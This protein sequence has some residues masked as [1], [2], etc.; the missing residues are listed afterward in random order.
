M[1]EHNH[2]PSPVGSV[3]LN[4]GEN[5]GALILEADASLLG[6]EIEISPVGADGRH[7][8]GSQRTHSM[9]RERH[10]VPH[11]RYDAVYPDLAAGQYT[12]WQDADVP[13]A[14]VTI[15]G[16]QITTLTLAHAAA[17]AAAETETKT[18]TTEAAAETK[19]EEAPSC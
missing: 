9:V 11:P 2:G 5:I 17:A 1:S 14:T 15:I 6:V 10:T 18:E 12:I 7:A 19:A 16:G 13:G 8:S 4:L 3:V